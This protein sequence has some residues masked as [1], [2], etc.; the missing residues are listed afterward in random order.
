MKVLR[1]AV[2]DG[3]AAA[4]TVIGADGAPAV[5]CGTGAVRLVRVQRA[6]RQAASGEEFLRGARGLDRVV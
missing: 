3:A 6:G 5:A 1:S 4:G 2:A